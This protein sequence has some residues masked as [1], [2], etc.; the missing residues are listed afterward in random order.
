MWRSQWPHSL[1]R[2]S[3]S[4]RFL[5]LRFPIQLMA[6]I[7]VSSVMCSQVEFSAKG[8]SFVRR[9]TKYVCYVC[10]WLSVTWELSHHYDLTDYCCRAM[11]QLLYMCCIFWDLCVSF[12]GCAAINNSRHDT[13]P[14]LVFVGV[15]TK[16]SK[17]LFLM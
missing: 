9:S 4:Y 17:Y 13:P 5:G 12:F 8:L 3:A 16:Q 7:S 10:V 14:A 15:K 6:R 1:R 11:K 2:G